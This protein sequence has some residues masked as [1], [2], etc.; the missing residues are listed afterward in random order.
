MAWTAPSTWVASATLTAAQL[1]QQLRDN[2]LECAPALANDEGGYFVVDD[3]NSIVQRLAE[4]AYVDAS[5][6][7][8]STSFVDLATVGPQVTVTS[9]VRAIVWYASQVSNSGAGGISRVAIDI[10]GATTQSGQDSQSLFF[11]STAANDAYNASQVV[12]FDTLTGGS[13]TFTLKYRVSAG[14]GTFTRRR[15]VVMPF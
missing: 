11:E 8:T 12:F 5:E 15:I 10:S 13:N 7:T 1:N 4:K 3:T 2:L 14:T 6:T 9:G